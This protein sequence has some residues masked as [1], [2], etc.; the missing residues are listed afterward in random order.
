MNGYG[1]NSKECKAVLDRVDVIHLHGRLGCLPWQ[2]GIN[3]VQFGETQITPQIYEMARKEIRIVHEKID[4]R[5]SE[6]ISARRIL[7]EAKRIY[8]MGF[9]YGR[10]NVD[11][12]KFGEVKT[13]VCEG[14]AL[15]L[16]NVERND[17]S[18]RLNGKVTLQ[19][20]DCL[21]FL[22]ERVDWN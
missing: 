9:G 14:T 11:R 10:Q 15:H 5:D 20:M 19:D 7:Q 16:T 18:R 1:K 17:I 4:D 8:F 6:F 3:V 13:E 12:L 21:A 22:R 2:E